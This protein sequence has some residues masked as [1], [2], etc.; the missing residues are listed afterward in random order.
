MRIS[1]HR[2]W[3]RRTFRWQLDFMYSFAGENELR[4]DVTHRITRASAPLPVSA[5]WEPL[6]AGA[7]L[8]WPSLLA[9]R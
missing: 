4:G 9:F 8:G 6:C 5:L 2:R 7:L 1:V 3:P